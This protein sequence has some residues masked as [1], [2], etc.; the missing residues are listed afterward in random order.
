M[1]RGPLLRE[2]PRARTLPG[3]LRP[4]V[5][6]SH[7]RAT[8]TRLSREFTGALRTTWSLLRG[9]VVGTSPRAR[10]LAGPLR[11]ELVGTS[12]G[13]QSLARPLLPGEL[14]RLPAGPGYG[15]RSPAGS[16]R[17]ELVGTS[18]RARTLARSLLP[19]ELARL[20]ARSGYGPRRLARPLLRELVGTG[21]WARTLA[22]SLWRELVGTGSRARGLAGSLLPGE[23]ARLPPYGTWRLTGPLLRELSR[24]RSG[25]LR[26]ELVGASPGV[27]RTLLRWQ[28][29]RAG[30]RSLSSEFV[31]TGMRGREIFRAPGARRLTRALMPGK[32]S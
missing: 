17:W 3:P 16:L 26:P 12:L 25:A 2:L 10:T 6:G 24:T 15:M 4:E 22:E 5:V 29:T 21:R 11:W 30:Q 8:R 1:R 32:L 20:S 9:E 14:A 28:T 27:A 18:I 19:G 23:L 13:P 7:A 31:G